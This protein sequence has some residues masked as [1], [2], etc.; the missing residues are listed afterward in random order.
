MEWELDSVAPLNLVNF[1]PDDWLET[2]PETSELLLFP[3][4]GFG[5]AL[6]DLVRQDD[7]VV[8]KEEDLVGFIRV[9]PLKKAIT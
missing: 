6:S 9:F 3:L 8:A 1:F 2:D 4:E 7:S 5:A